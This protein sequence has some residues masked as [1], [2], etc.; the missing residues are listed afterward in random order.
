MQWE[1]GQWSI[2]SSLHSPDVL[3]PTYKD[4]VSGRVSDKIWEDLT[5][6]AEAIVWLVQVKYP[7]CC[8]SVCFS[9]GLFIFFKGVFWAKFIFMGRVLQV[10]SDE[11]VGEPVHEDGLCCCY[12]HGEVH[13]QLVPGSSHRPTLRRRLRQQLQTQSA[14]L[15]R[16]QRDKMTD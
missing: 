12:G 11:V 5:Q 8:I 15:T 13:P 4:W 3:L 6:T 1:E 7:W 14:D 16:V 10:L 2:T 9:W